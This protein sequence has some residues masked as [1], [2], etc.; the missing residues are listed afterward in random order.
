MGMSLITGTWQELDP[1]LNVHSSSLS[2]LRTMS[3][4]PALEWNKAEGKRLN[5]TPQLALS[6]VVGK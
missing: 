5:L 4:N 2:H 3:E 6:T 1:F